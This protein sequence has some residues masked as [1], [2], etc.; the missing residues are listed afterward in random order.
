MLTTKSLSTAGRKVFAIA[1]LVGAAIFTASGSFIHFQVVLNDFWGVLYYG[2]HLSIFQPVSLYNGFF[3]IGYPFLLSFIPDNYVI[4]YAFALNILFSALFLGWLTSLF[5]SLDKSR[6]GVG[7]VC[8]AAV[9]YPLFFQYANT[10]SPD[11]GAAAFSIGGVYLL[12]LAELQGREQSG[13][14]IRDDI[15]AGLLFGFSALFRSHGIISAAAIL[16]AY[17]LTCGFRRLWQRKALALS[18]GL[19]Y[20][21]QVAA[22]LLS[23]HGPLETAQNFNAYIS[24]YSLNWWHLPPEVYSFSLVSQFIKHPAGF[25]A[26]YIPLFLHLMVFG[27]PALLCLIFLRERYHKKFAWF[28]FLATLFYALPVAIGTALTDR[29]PLPILGMTITCA[30]LLGLEAWKRARNWLAFSKALQILAAGLL[31]VAAVWIASGWGSSNLDFLVLNRGQYQNLQIIEKT[32]VERGA[33]KPSQVFT[34]NFDL[35]FP[36]NPPYRLYSNGGWEDY[37]LWNYRQEFPELPTDSWEAFSTAAAQKHIRFLALSPGAGALA[38]F[39]ND[40]YRERFHP[41]GVELIGSVGLNKIYQ[42]QK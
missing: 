17:S 19:V 9:L 24:F 1:F 16:L 12:W 7:L 30:G 37:S 18:L 22:N 35:Y 5:Y 3:P 38:G 34:N 29:G 28:V 21:I 36:D 40:L 6:W 42:L 2:K 31:A 13:H 39:L 33:T 15:L 32:L 27:A 8:L 23:G 25:I 26:I 41:P 4:Y 10:I 20:L 14:P 11:L